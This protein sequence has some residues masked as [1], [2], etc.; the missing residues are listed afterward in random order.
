MRSGGWWGVLGSL[1][2]VMAACTSGATSATVGTTGSTTSVSGTI[3]ENTPAPTT[4]TSAPEEGGIVAG[5][6]ALF[7]VI[8]EPTTL[9]P[10]LE[11]AT[12][13]FS[14][15]LIGQ[16]V[17]TGVQD[18]DALRRVPI[19]EVVSELPT[20]ENGGLVVNDD[21]TLTVT[22]EIR[23]EAVWE[24]GTPVSGF[25]FEFT[26]QTITN[27]RLPIRGSI[28][29]AHDAILRSSIVAEEKRFQYVLGEPSLQY[30]FLF[31]IILPKHEVEGSSF[32]R[33]WDDRM[34]MSAGPFR[35]AEWE[36]G[37]RLRLERNPNY[38]KTDP[39]GRELPYL[40]GLEFRFMED[41]V[42]LVSAFK[43]RAV[44]IINPPARSDVIDEL[45]ALE[46]L[47]A[48]VQVRRG[49]EWEHLN[50]QFGPGRFE[51]NA[52]SLNEHRLYRQALA[53]LVDREAITA[54]ILDGRLD[55]LDSFVDLYWPDASQAAWSRYPYDPAE[56]GRLLGEL[57][58]QLGRDFSAEPPRAVFTTTNEPERIRLAEI[59]VRSF[60]EAGID[61]VVELEERAVFFG[62]SVAEGNFDVGEWA[63][64][65]GQ[66]RSGLV[67]TLRDLFYLRP[68]NGLN[69]YRW[70]PFGEP[71]E[72]ADRAYE[73]LEG[74]DRV[75]DDR[76]LRDQIG[77]LERILADQVVI[78]PLYT[79]PDV[80]VV[81]ADEIAGYVHNPTMAGDTW[82]VETWYRPGYEP[83]E[84]PSGGS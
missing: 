31:N 17:W 18:I 4:T 58:S 9:N 15:R 60:A 50:F 30:E 40:D 12:A 47:G 37:E 34:W 69:Y 6:E 32:T 71:N 23:D 72:S 21:G 52:E 38:W 55:P 3:P 54:S 67:R 77:E 81:W 1:L 29:R 61:L 35:F 8:E 10:L 66:G 36:K 82:N 19:P 63:W 41:P 79:N 84:V 51:R 68:P 33:D 24:D 43:R 42:A 11:G 53:H 27:R 45:D 20:V 14:L 48:D 49:P 73:I 2:V 59:L 56:A 78:I 83:P 5:G 16:A 62:D 64:I 39:E 28:R 22:Y 13:E 7:G 80:G 57:G 74:L 26:Y 76:A 65:A 25:D 44:D 46:V 70:G 75:I